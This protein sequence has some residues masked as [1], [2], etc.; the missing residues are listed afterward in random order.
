MDLITDVFP[1]AGLYNTLRCPV[2]DGDSRRHRPARDRRLRSAPPTRVPRARPGA[3]LVRRRRPDRCRRRACCRSRRAGARPGPPR[4]RACGAVLPRSGRDRRRA[5]GDDA[6][7]H[8][9]RST[10][11]APRGIPGRVTYSQLRVAA[12]YDPIA[13]RAFWKINGMICPPC[14]GLHRPGC[15][16]AHA[17]NSQTARHRAASRPANPGA[18]PHRPYLGRGL[19]ASSLTQPRPTRPPWR[20]LRNRAERRIRYPADARL[21]WSKAITGDQVPLSSRRI[22][23]NASAFPIASFTGLWSWAVFLCR[24]QPCVSLQ[25]RFRLLP[26]RR[27]GGRSARTGCPSRPGRTCQY[28]PPVV[29]RVVAHE[30]RPASS[31]RCPRSQAAKILGNFLIGRYARADDADRRVFRVR[32]RANRR[33]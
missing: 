23:S 12:S 20:H 18:V 4:R 10:A 26:G 6:A 7:H 3:G 13:F 2:I 29:G 30:D 15:R 31:P 27:C 14:R 33:P 24:F 28:P 19:H 25:S 8:L 16:S 11:F 21:G 5:A 1:M 22:S 32:R 9:R 17:G